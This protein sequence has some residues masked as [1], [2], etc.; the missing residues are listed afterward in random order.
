MSLQLSKEIW[1]LFGVSLE[2]VYYLVIIILIYNDK[3]K[4]NQITE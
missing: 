2:A 1:S 4:L 3:K